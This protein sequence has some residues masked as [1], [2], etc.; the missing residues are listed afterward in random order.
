MSEVQKPV[1]EP[2]AAPAPAT[3][4][5][6]ATEPIVESATEEAPAA[7]ADVTTEAPVAEEP[8]TE[9]AAEA[10]PAAKEVKPIEEGVLGYKG[11]GLLKS[12]IFQKKFF[13]FGSEPV[14]SKHL[15]TYL[16]GEKPD[17]ANHNAAWSAHTGK[18]LFYFSKKAT[19]KASP[20]GIINLSEVSDVTE[21]GTVDFFFTISGHKHTFQAANLVD[22]DSW[23]ATLKTKVAEAKE[24]ADE[25]PVEEAAVAPVA[26]PVATET[27]PVEEV[28]VT[29]APATE[30]APVVAPAAEEAVSPTTPAEKPLPTKRS[31]IF[32]TLQSRFS[33]KKPEPE[34]AAP[35]VP[36]KDEES[37]SENA[38]VIPA[39]ESTEPLAESVEPVVPAEATEAPAVN[40]ETKAP[41]APVTKADKRKS[42]LPWLTKKEK[43][44]TSDD[45]A[46]K[47][48]SP[49]AKL[50]ATVKGKSSPKTEKTAEKPV[51]PTAES[52]IEENTDDK[53]PEEETPAAEAAPV[54][55]EPVVAEPVAAAPVSAPQVSATA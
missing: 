39:A 51:E 38:P 31:S 35:A 28:P 9:T 33:H 36:A 8:A 30:E 54:V 45:E 42:T 52:K 37:V 49:F 17:V 55:S 24:I 27:A 11:P 23:V 4:E 18:G 34:A 43:S 14:E 10:A 12:F 3:I 5:T 20:A 19:D 2:V 21:D 13:W 16:R 46:E 22:R 6:P 53:I 40:G 44:A 29:E 1:E 15:T 26:E 41:E 25:A 32:G 7:T 47:P 48:L 50:R